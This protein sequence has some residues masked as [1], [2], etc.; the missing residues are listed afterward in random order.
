MRIVSSKPAFQSH[1][2]LT[3]DHF[4]E[5]WTSVMTD[6]RDKENS[7]A[8]NG[9]FADDPDMFAVWVD[10][11]LASWAGDK[12]WPDGRAEN[13][14][15]WASR[16]DKKEIEKFWRGF[17]AYLARVMRIVICLETGCIKGFSQG[18]LSAPGSAVGDSL[19]SAFL[20][21]TPPSPSQYVKN[22][23][24][25]VNSSTT[26]QI[27]AEDALTLSALLETAAVKWGIKKVCGIWVEIG[28][29]EHYQVH[30]VRLHDGSD[31]DKVLRRCGKKIVVNIQA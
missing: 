27:L 10:S 5:L 30:P 22:A 6:L 24:D 11:S 21:A 28:S 15:S 13:R 2:G 12:Y 25:L 8:L 17:V 31:W 16:D 7:V 3:T 18:C 23:L 20:F 26:K 9:P 14:L 1:S 29:G 19:K 4:E